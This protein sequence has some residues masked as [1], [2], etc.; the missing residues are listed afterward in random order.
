MFNVFFPTAVLYNP[1]ACIDNQY[2][3]EW[4]PCSQTC[5]IG[6]RSRKR[7]INNGQLQ[8]TEEEYCNLQY[9]PGILLYC[10]K[11]L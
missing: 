4:S 5:D 1:V 6:T 7:L 9:C 2:W 11:T 3:E 8:E 10:N